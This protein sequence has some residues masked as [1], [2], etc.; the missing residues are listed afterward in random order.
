MHTVQQLQHELANVREAGG[1]KTNSSGA[2]QTIQNSGNQFDAHGN[3][4][5]SANISADNIS[6]FTSTDDK[7]TQVHVCFCGF[8]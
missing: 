4:A 5:E 7:A 3:S 1:S 2:S 6:S 8:S